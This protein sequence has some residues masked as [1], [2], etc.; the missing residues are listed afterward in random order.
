MMDF[1]S[2]IMNA[3][4]QQGAAAPQQAMP[5]PEMGAAAPPQPN[6]MAQDVI[7][8]RRKFQMGRMAGGGGYTG[9]GGNAGPMME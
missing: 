8:A 7:N 6:P 1:L 4:P 2:Q 3:M 5:P 9:M